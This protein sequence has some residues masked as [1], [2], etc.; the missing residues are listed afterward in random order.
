MSFNFCNFTWCTAHSCAMQRTN[1]GISQNWRKNR[2]SQHGPLGPLDPQMVH[3]RGPRSIAHDPPNFSHLQSLGSHNCPLGR[4][5]II[6]GVVGF[7][8]MHMLPLRIGIG[9]HG[10]HMVGDIRYPPQLLVS[11][12]WGCNT[13]VVPSQ[14]PTPSKILFLEFLL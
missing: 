9:G 13:L 1:F 11:L 7:M 12:G 8:L 6:K 2:F 3:Q 10:P 14:G 4:W 5:G